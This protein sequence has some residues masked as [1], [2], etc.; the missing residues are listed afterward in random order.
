MTERF[1][2]KP[3][4]GEQINWSHPLAQG[5]VGMWLFNEG[6]GNTIYDL[7][8][9]GNNGILTNMVPSDDWVAGREGWVL[10]FDGTDDFVDM[11]TAFD[12]E[13]QAQL[14]R[15]EFTFSIWWKSG[16]ASQTNKGLMGEWKNNKGAFLWLNSSGIISMPIDGGTHLAGTTDIRVL[17]EWFNI[18][19]TFDGATSRIYV[20]GVEEGNQSESKAVQTT[21]ISGE[22][23]RYDENNAVGVN[24]QL[25][26]ALFYKRALTAQEVQS[27]YINPYAMFERSLFGRIFVPDEVITPIVSIPRRTSIFYRV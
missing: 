23:G 26:N 14:V 8:L 3:L 17:N 12:E 6:S 13:N 11:G 2:R 1:G 20:N 16:N 4:L 22:I 24:G 21:G 19:G 5:L 25:T 9:S 15:A 10:D 27:L 18:V 7:S